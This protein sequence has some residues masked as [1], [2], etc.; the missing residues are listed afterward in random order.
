MVVYKQ[1]QNYSNNI[2]YA[3]IYP[4]I[5]TSSYIFISDFFPKNEDNLY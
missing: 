5:S 1:A 2:N 3:I 4:F